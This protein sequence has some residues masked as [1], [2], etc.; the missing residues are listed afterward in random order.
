VRGHRGPGRRAL[1]APRNPSAD[2]R[3]AR[4]K[5]DMGHTLEPGSGPALDAAQSIDRPGIRRHGQ[6]TKAGL[7]CLNLVPNRAG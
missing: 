1:T 3:N 4:L 5:P 6:G 7:M 2:N